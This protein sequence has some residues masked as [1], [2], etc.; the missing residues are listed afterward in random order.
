MARCNPIEYIPIPGYIYA[1]NWH[2][3]E[4]PC[5]LMTP[6]KFNDPE[7]VVWQNLIEFTSIDNERIRVSW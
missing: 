3:K 4:I 1:Y 7:F 2:D 5:A 6:V